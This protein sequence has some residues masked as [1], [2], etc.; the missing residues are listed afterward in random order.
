MSNASTALGSALADQS[1]ARH[2]VELALPMIES[3]M[4]SRSIGESG[5]LY[6][7]IMDPALGPEAC[8]F[9]SAILYEHSVGDRS[10]WDADYALYAREKARVC[11]RGRRS[12]HELRYIAPHL[13]RATDT[14]VWGG[15]WHDGIAVGVS[16]ADPWF[17]EA[18]GTSVAGLLR[19]IA[20]QRALALQESLELGRHDQ[21]GAKPLAST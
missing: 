5:F 3:G 9:E 1:A 17:D 21:G 16:G 7:V 20:K 2:A 11:W 10:A 19:A 6:I 13:L 14:G 15:V 18:I 8:S 4:A 12:G